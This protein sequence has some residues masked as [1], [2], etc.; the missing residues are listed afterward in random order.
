MTNLLLLLSWLSQLSGAIATDIEMLG[1]GSFLSQKWLQCMWPAQ[2]SGP[3]WNMQ[4]VDLANLTTGQSHQ[5]CLKALGGPLMV[6]LVWHDYPAAVSAKTA[7]INDLDLTVR[8]A[9]LDGFPLLVRLACFLDAWLSSDTYQ[10]HAPQPSSSPLSRDSCTIAQ[11]PAFGRACSVSA[12]LA[13]RGMAGASVAGGPSRPTAPTMWSR[14]RCPTSLR[15]MSPSRS[16]ALC[17]PP[18]LADCLRV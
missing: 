2:G 4:L 11:P 13:C 16:A 15:G 8:A 10:T 14:P 1:K 18:R 17:T 12:G 3:G 5:Y 7:L 9:G 6:T